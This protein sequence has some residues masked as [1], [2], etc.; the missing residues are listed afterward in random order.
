LG[1]YKATLTIIPTQP[2]AYYLPKDAIN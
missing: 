2:A 1:F